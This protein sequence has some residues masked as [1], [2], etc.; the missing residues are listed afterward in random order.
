[1]YYST[2]LL[3][4][5]NLSARDIC[6]FYEYLADE[7]KMRKKISDNLHITEVK[8]VDEIDSPMLTVQIYFSVYNKNITSSTNYIYKCYRSV[9]WACSNKSITK[10]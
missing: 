2:D 7:F 1:M 10:I 6:E 5:S 8:V 9:T 3:K 4:N